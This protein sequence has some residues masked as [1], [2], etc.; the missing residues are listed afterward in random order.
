M[1][2]QSEPYYSPATF[3]FLSGLSRH[4]ERSWFEAHRVDYEA[5][6]RAP[7]LRLIEALA[8]PLR[9]VSAHLVADARPVGG[10]LFRIH[11]DTRFSAD[12]R[13]YKT[14]LGMTF[15]HA[16][17]RR[18]ARSAPGSAAP[19][20]LDAPVL[21]V[22]VEPGRSFVG[23]GIWRPQA[24]TL[25]RLRDFMID[26]PRSWSHATARP[27]FT[28][29]FALGGESLVR[30]PRGYPPTHP[31]ILDLRRKDLVANA[32]LGD[33]DVMDPAFPTMLMQRFRLMRPMLE[34]LCLALD[35]D[36]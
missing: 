17:T 4:N 13:P 19:G 12:K 3:R 30:P 32:V 7:S 5:H 33:D 26:N 6:V 35:L 10:S 16:S 15:F 27:G 36:F 28:R 11:R 2:R 22:H 21:Y 9:T 31:L 18:G 34:W 8:A 23:G 25:K 29:R 24:P 1:G 20:R 14:H